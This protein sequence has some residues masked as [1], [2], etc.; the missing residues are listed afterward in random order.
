MSCLLCGVEEDLHRCTQCSDGELRT[1]E[2]MID[3]EN[4]KKSHVCTHLA[5]FN[6]RKRKP[7][8]LSVYEENEGEE[9]DEEG[10]KEVSKKK[11][12]K[13]KMEENNGAE[14]GD[15]PSR[16]D[17]VDSKALRSAPKE[18]VKNSS[19]AEKAKTSIHP[20]TDA[21]VSAV[22]S[23]L[24]IKSGSKKGGSGKLEKPKGLELPGGVI[25][26]SALMYTGFEEVRKDGKKF[27]R[28]KMASAYIGE[29]RGSA[30]HGEC[31]IQQPNIGSHV[32][33]WHVDFF[34]RDLIG[35]FDTSGGAGHLGTFYEENFG[36]F[37]QKKEEDRNRAKLAQEAHEKRANM[38]KITNHFARPPDRHA[39]VS[40]VEHMMDSQGTA[41][42]MVKVYIVMDRLANNMSLYS[43]EAS[44]SKWISWAM[45]V[46]R[47]GPPDPSLMPSRH[48]VNNVIVPGLKAVL[49]QKM[50][51]KLRDLQVFAMTTDGWSA[52]NVERDHFASVTLHFIDQN[53][54]LNCANPGIFAT[55][56]ACSGM[57]IAKFINEFLGCEILPPQA[58][59]N[60]IVSDSAANQAMGSRGVVGERGTVFC[61][62]HLLRLC[63]QHAVKAVPKVEEM[64]NTCVW[65]CG[66]FSNNTHLNG[67]LKSKLQDHQQKAKKLVSAVK[68]R[69]DTYVCSMRSV[70]AVLD[71]ILE[72]SC[73]D[74]F[75]ADQRERIR[76]LDYRVMENVL[77]VLAPFVD[78]LDLM[79]TE[80]AV[81]ISCVPLL[82]QRLLQGTEADLHDAVYLTEFKAALHDNVK[83]RFVDPYLS[84]PSPAI[85][86]ALCDP[87]F[88]SDFLVEKCKVK[89]EVLDEAKEALVDEAVKLV[90]LTKGDGEWREYDRDLARDQ[91]I[92][93]LRVLS[94]VPQDLAPLDTNPLEWWRDIGVKE[95]TQA[96][97]MMARAYLC[98]PASSTSSERSFSIGSQIM[99]SKRANLNPNTLTDVHMLSSNQHLLDGLC[100][101]DFKEVVKELIQQ[102]EEGL[103]E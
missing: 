35:K 99:T 30:T 26:P 16:D 76:S 28:C 50:R 71:L 66:K 13:K 63:M 82:V 78:M 77:A 4:M 79:G 68:T 39:N 19:S 97:Q 7:R 3:H 38:A 55:E 11:V 59:C 44:Q 80:S 47:S 48:E 20:I 74:D 81:S 75:S 45:S 51:F 17:Q 42:C 88:S 9:E 1:L 8:R 10:F 43:A 56:G 31:V 23:A 34:T 5:A 95:T 73:L 49:L 100:A 86:A 60:A 69:F 25:L 65:L 58:I 29:M 12:R 46:G 57:N 21:E 96:A 52:R 54:Q 53:W 61:F 37:V 98:T 33:R 2:E 6:P 87:R 67:V 92:L 102:N 40:G 70:C 89:L 101:D 91:I 90:R 22:R 41:R 83:K 14:E 15:E 84:Q 85:F 32:K 93:A 62:Q 27:F 103:N 94:H 36:L 64:H 18:E 24:T 72:M